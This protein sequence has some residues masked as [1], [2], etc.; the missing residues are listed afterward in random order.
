MGRLLYRIVWQMPGYDAE[1]ISVITFQDNLEII[2][3]AVQDVPDY[4][5][6]TLIGQNYAGSR[7]SIFY[8]LAHGANYVT[9]VREPT[10]A[11]YPS[12]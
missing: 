9:M 11:A 1:D 2:R 10:A 6:I 5:T 4:L 3:T 7:I 12:Y 8:I